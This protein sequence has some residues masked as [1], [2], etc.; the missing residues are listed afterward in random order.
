[1]SGGGDGG[2]TTLKLILMPNNLLT[3]IVLW[4]KSSVRVMERNGCV[5]D[6][7]DSSSSFSVSNQPLFVTLVAFRFTGLFREAEA[8][9]VASC[10]SRSF[11]NTRR[12]FILEFVRTVVDP[13]RLKTINKIQDA[14]EYHP[15]HSPAT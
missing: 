14:A 11:R 5:T 8:A 6:G 10:L 15:E 13:A 7:M 2:W 1:M 9:I 3:L 12:I 4:L